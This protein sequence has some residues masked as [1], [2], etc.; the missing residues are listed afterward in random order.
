M[1]DSSVKVLMVGG[2]RAG[3]TSILAGLYDTMLSGEVSEVIKLEDK[4]VRLPGQETME[5]KIKSLKNIISTF[6]GR[7]FLVDDSHT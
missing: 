1:A 3:K 2:A 4:T 6:Q 5:D 7:T